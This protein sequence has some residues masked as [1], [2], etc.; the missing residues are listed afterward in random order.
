M[1][2][3]FIT[4]NDLV[5]DW[6]KHVAAGEDY[7]SY[8]GEHHETTFQVPD[9]RASNKE[10]R[11]LVLFMDAQQDKSNTE[12]SLSCQVGAFWKGDA[13][14]RSLFSKKC[15]SIEEAQSLFDGMEVQLHKIDTL[16]SVDPAIAAEQTQ[17]FFKGVAGFAQP[18][19][20]E[21]TF[22]NHTMS[23][24]VPGWDL[25]SSPNCIQ[26][27][28][29]DDF[30]KT[31]LRKFKVA[32][33]NPLG[34]PH[35]SYST[36]SR[37]HCGADNYT[38]SYWSRALTP[39]GN[40]L[41]N[42]ITVTRVG[43][44][45]PS[46]VMHGVSFDNFNQVC[47]SLTPDA[48]QYGLQYDSVT[49]KWTKTAGKAVIQNIFFESREDLEDFWKS[50]KNVGE[51]AKKEVSKKPK[52]GEAPEAEEEPIEPAPSISLEDIM[53]G[54]PGE[55][56]A[57][58]QSAP[59]PENV[60]STSSFKNRIEKIAALPAKE[61]KEGDEVIYMSDEGEI[62]GK[63]VKNED[64]I[65]TLNDGKGDHSHL[66]EEEGISVFVSPGEYRGLKERESAHQKK[67]NEE[68][69]N[70]GP[71]FDTREQSDDV[72]APKSV[73]EIVEKSEEELEKEEEEAGKDE[74]QLAAEDLGEVEEKGLAEHASSL[75]TAESYWC[76]CGHVPSQHENGTGM[77]TWEDS[78]KTQ[79]APAEACK[80]QKYEA[81]DATASM[82]PFLQ[83][84]ATSEIYVE[85][86]LLSW[87][88]N[89]WPQGLPTKE[90][91]EIYNAMLVNF[92]NDLRK[93]IHTIHENWK[94]S[95]EKH[96]K[97][98]EL[99]SIVANAQEEIDGTK[100]EHTKGQ[101]EKQQAKRKQ[102]M[103]EIRKSMKRGSV[104][105]DAYKAALIAKFKEFA[106]LSARKSTDDP[107]KDPVE[108]AKGSKELR[109]LLEDE[110]KMQTELDGIRSRLTQLT[111]TVSAKEEE[112]WEMFK[113][114]PDQN[115]QMAQVE[116][117]SQKL[118]QVDDLFARYLAQEGP[119][120]TAN[121]IEKFQNMIEKLE[122]E[123]ADSMKA[124]KLP[125]AQQ[126]KADEAIQGIHQMQD[127]LMKSKDWESARS[128]EKELADLEKKK[129][130]LMDETGVISS[131][132]IIYEVFKNG[133]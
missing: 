115:E 107:F 75:K 52:G 11:P 116:A 65:I 7:K 68:K 29:S 97:L 101:L 91:Q 104:S 5:P 110:H 81:R 133:A 46:V 12:G 57:A 32:S 53:K 59:S 9:L 3:D 61:L 41:K 129:N 130:A 88:K 27:K 114:L 31:A 87:L 37:T 96:D 15:K 23:S 118:M 78:N 21:K 119:V 120:T 71:E 8:K 105:D 70:M 80:C 10:S 106:H 55:E 25:V 30:I 17:D 90:M 16:S 82:H 13:Q 86:G 66:T 49:A 100:D 64:G 103:D 111:Q 102:E 40:I 85:A 36:D 72:P 122:K 54:G 45:T 95:R 24:F 1:S 38:V 48:N 79:E 112:L 26:V 125:E 93:Q 34:N 42:I 113:G 124:A 43:N 63:V 98:L 99:E 4:K 108:I 123:R 20:V 28:F 132:N 35:A 58:A 76:K 94:A 126:A 18:A 84:L 109:K 121:G 44:S 131:L 51:G 117:V 19:E 39:E 14:G 128:L 62:K 74:G 2:K 22:D 127:D 73:D 89:D 6:L 77:C 60:P 50:T 69:R 47:S 33:E 83:A 67:K 56:S 92:R